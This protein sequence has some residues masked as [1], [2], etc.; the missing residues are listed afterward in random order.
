MVRRGALASRRAA[1]YTLLEV[2]VAMAVF[3]IF[4][5]VVGVLTTEMRTQERRMPIDFMRHPQVM[6]LVARIRRDVLD[7]HGASPYRPTHDG[8]TQGPK[9]LI[10]ETVQQ[11]GG[12]AMVVWDFST[13]GQALR[14]A[15]NVGVATEWRARGLPAEFNIEPVRI[16]GRPWGARL[17]ADRDGVRTIDLILQPRAHE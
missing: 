1:G 3:G 9:T 17:T 5:L 4:L 7:A 14:R 8:F 13:P 15:Y 10:L 2:V 12:V 16:Y 6:S 11:H